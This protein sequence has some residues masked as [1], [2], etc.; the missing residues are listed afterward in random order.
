MRVKNLR[1][2][3]RWP[4]NLLPLIWSLF[5]PS[6]L[7]DLD[8]SPRVNRVINC[9]DD[10]DVGK[11]L[12]PRRLWLLVPQNAIRKV[13]QFCGKLIPLRKASRLLPAGDRYVPANAFCVFVGGICAKNA[14]ASNQRIAAHIGSAKTAGKCS[15]P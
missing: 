1:L 5:L 14:L 7:R 6:R 4:V 11:A 12:P 15:Q 10:S 9:L 3:V 8:R 13:R 2:P